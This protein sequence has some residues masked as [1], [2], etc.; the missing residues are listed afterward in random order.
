MQA[1]A[2]HDVTTVS[3]ECVNT[4]ALRQVSK[5]LGL[6]AL[7]IPPF[8]YEPSKLRQVVDR[9]DLYGYESDVSEDEDSDEGEEPLLT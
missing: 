4:Q 6:F 7:T 2:I 3:T 9:Y 1:D 5:N 8:G